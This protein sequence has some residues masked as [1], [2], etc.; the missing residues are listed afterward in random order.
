MLGAAS[1][2]WHGTDAELLRRNSV[3][4]RIVCVC[5]S[6]KVSGNGKT[7]LSAVTFFI[8]IAF[9]C[10]FCSG[11]T[12]KF[13]PDIPNREKVSALYRRGYRGLAIAMILSPPAAYAFNKFTCQNSLVF[14]AEAFGIVAFGT[15]RLVK[16]KELSLSDEERRA[17][18]GELDANISS[19]R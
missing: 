13:M 9:V 11:K 4:S 5:M 12:L 17:W 16:R 15:Y 19:L 6:S 8:C 1:T 14:W 2:H 3:C 18:K 10:I 7:L